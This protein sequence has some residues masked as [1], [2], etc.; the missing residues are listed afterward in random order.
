MAWRRKD[1]KPLSEPMLTRF[2][3]AYMRHKGG[4]VKSCSC[5]S[6]C[7]RLLVTISIIHAIL[8]SH[9]SL[10]YVHVQAESIL[11]RHNGH[12]GVSNHQ[13]CN[14]LL[15]LVLRRR[16]KKTLKLRVTGL[17]AGNSPV[18]GEFSPQM[19]SKSA[20]VSIWW[21]HHDNLGPGEGGVSLHIASYPNE[22]S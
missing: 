22:V 11:W 13:P 14:S 5:G 20:N 6:L 16:S 10:T 9:N 2:T 21:R 8:I 15:N 12:S 4:W 1:D 3:E 17:C 18:A 7:R 19:A